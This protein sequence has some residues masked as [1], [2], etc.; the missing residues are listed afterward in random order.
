MAIDVRL[1]Q[2]PETPRSVLAADGAVRGQGPEIP[3]DEL[4]G[5]YGKMRLAR[6][7][8]EYL[9][10]LMRQGRLGFHLAGH[11][12][13]AVS[14]ATAYV[15]ERDDWLF[16]AFR[17]VPAYLVRGVELGT[18]AHQAFGSSRSPTL[19]R[20]L[21]LYFADREHRI[22]MPGAGGAAHLPHAV[23]AA[24]AA[25]L[26]QERAVAIASFNQGAVAS[27]EF[28]AALNFAGVFHAPVLFVCRRAEGPAFPESSARVHGAKQ[29]KKTGGPPKREREILVPASDAVASRAKGYGMPGVRVD[30][31]DLLALIAALRTA[32]DR[33]RA[34]EGPTLIE[35]LL[36]GRDPVDLLRRHLVHRGAWDDAREREAGKALGA[37]VLAAVREAVA[38]GPPPIET[39]WKDT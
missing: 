11:G 10:D 2:E 36:G 25:R 3:P 37:S 29:S 7:F 21:P 14:A 35:A 1:P 22:A 23:G 18:L 24:W 20:P 34:G 31:S 27:G 5:L 30:G 13:E 32:A 15:L 33:A 16:P 39:L 9:G 19:G 6:S 12:E 8:D 26:R 28:H 38:A 4:V 17:D